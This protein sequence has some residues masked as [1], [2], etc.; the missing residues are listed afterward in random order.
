MAVCAAPAYKQCVCGG[1]TAYNIKCGYVVGYAGYL[2][3]AYAH[4]AFVVDRVG[5]YSACPYVAFQA[6]QT[7][8]AAF[9]T[10]DRPVADIIFIAHY[11][12]PR[13]VVHAFRHVMRAYFRIFISF[14]Y[15]PCARSVAD[16]GVAQE[17]DRC[18]VL[19]GY[20]RCLECHCEAVGGRCRCYNRHG[21]FTVTAIECLHEVG[22]L[23]LCGK[24]C[25]RTA[26]LHIDDN[27]RE[28]RHHCK[29]NAFAL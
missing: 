7:V 26:T 19:D 4:H 14:G 16:E 22:L 17:D 28:F 3:P 13:T 8:G 10:G 6:S 18:H 24:P 20:T 23:C 12:T 2:F 29:A 5:G 9:C 21:R 1:I 25:R 27:Q 15:A 11:G